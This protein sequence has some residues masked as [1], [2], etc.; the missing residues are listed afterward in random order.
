MAALMPQGKQQYFTA[1]GIPLVGGKVYT[2]AAG[3]TTPLATYTTAAASTPN[4]NPVI[5]DSRGEASIFFSA[6]NY[7]IVVKDSLDSTIWTQDDLAGDAAA[8]VLTRLALSTGSSLVGHIASGTGAVAITVQAKLRES[9]SVK[10]FG[11]LGDGVADDT[12]AIN[13]AIA[14]LTA[15]GGILIFPTGVYKISSTI[16]WANNITYKGVG[17]S[18][19]NTRGSVLLFSVTG[20][21]ASQISNALNSGTFASINFEGLTFV[22]AALSSGYALLYDTGSSYL[23]INKCKFNHA[24]AGSFGVVFDQTEISTI[25]RCIF[26]ATANIGTGANIWL[27]NGATP[28]N[29]TGAIYYTN[30]IGITNNQINPALGGAL[31]TGIL[32]SGGIAHT[33]EDNNF[34]SGGYY[35]KIVTGAAISIKRN[36]MEGA[37]VYGIAFITAAQGAT[38][39]EISNNYMLGAVPQLYMEAGAVDRIDYSNNVLSTSL[40]IACEQG[41]SAGVSGKISASNNRQI[42]LGSVPFN[43]YLERDV[44]TVGYCTLYGST[45]AGTQTY[46]AQT[47]TW[48]RIGDMCFFNLYLALTAKDAAMAGN[49]R[50]GGLPFPSK[51]ALATYTSVSIGWASFITLDAG[52]TQLGAYITAGQSYIELSEIKSATS[53]ANVAAA[54]IANNSQI[55]VSGMYPI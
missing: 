13:L 38:A 7:K 2:Y 18:T 27:A 29:P 45:T 39:I 43:N 32:D 8:A 37:T 9:V 51:A 55:M 3:T 50:I 14:Y 17:Y 44:D 47:I 22:H 25:D 48:R 23:N 26:E 21:N 4:T 40:G 35:I 52:Y 41:L 19:S 11:A 34:N 42:G 1:G 24:G 54:N 36:E 20:A 33:I 12:A 10:D 5:L 6:A 31:A 30:R 15:I 28:Q 53:V 46:A 49:T 16:T